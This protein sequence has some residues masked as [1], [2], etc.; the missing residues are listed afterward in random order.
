MENEKTLDDV[1]ENAD[2]DVANFFLS[3]IRAMPKSP[4]RHVFDELEITDRN[5]GKPLCKLYGVDFVGLRT[6]D[7]P[8][9]CFPTFQ[10]TF[11]FK[12]YPID[13]N[14]QA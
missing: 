13:K 8:N 2:A 12:D 3:W 4:P 14:T 7:D 11:D 1:L 6:S 10:F 5:T 9:S